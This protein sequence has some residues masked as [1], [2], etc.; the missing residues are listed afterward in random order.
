MKTINTALLS[1]GL[2]GKVFHAPF[3]KAHKG[4][5]LAG[6][7]ERSKKSIGQDYPGARSYTS[8][9]ELLHDPQ[10]EL[11]IVNTPT[12]THFEFARKA[13]LAGKHVVVE[14]AFTTTSAEAYELAQ[15][16][17]Q[18]H[19]ILSVYHNRRWDSD[20]MAVQQVIQDGLLGEVVEAQISYERFNPQLSAK[21]HRESPG[22]GAGNLMDLGP[23]CIDQALVLF[24]MPEAVF[25]DLRSCRP[26]SLVDDY[27]ELL[28]YYPSKRVRLKSSYLVREPGPAYIFH[29][30]K[31]TLLK[32]RSDVQEGQLREGMIPDEAFFGIEPPTAYGTLYKPGI[33]SSD[34]IESPRGN[35]MHFFELLHL[36]VI[37]GSPVPVSA[38][39]GIRVMRVLDA[40]AE[41]H[42]TQ[43]VIRLL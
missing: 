37:T 34:P 42:R 4:Y 10:V 38:E 20:F 3:I 2:S 35:Y 17:L 33:D 22:P 12:N 9:E 16:A 29:G 36:A 28:L 41:S 43:S 40:A 13:L 27:F 15:L 21:T 31:G 18:Q 32:Y 24:G 14:K 19:R 5:H 26:G 8:L 11:V 30:T 6:A 7:W 39:D 25:A 23:H 1:Y